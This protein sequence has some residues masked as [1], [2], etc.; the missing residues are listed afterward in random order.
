MLSLA[1]QYPSPL[2]QTAIKWSPQL[3][4]RNF[5]PGAVMQ[6]I[7]S[8]RTMAETGDAG[9]WAAILQGD[10]EGLGRAAEAFA[11]GLKNATTNPDLTLRDALTQA[12]FFEAPAAA[13]T[14]FTAELG[15]VFTGILLYSIREG[16]ELNEPTTFADAVEAA[17]AVVEAGRA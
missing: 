12:G 1:K 14:V 8:C 15:R 7:V 13:R 6:T 9:D 16:T 4:V 11:L 17:V 3:D 5:G 10:F 2:G